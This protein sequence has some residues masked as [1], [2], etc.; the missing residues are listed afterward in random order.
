[1]VSEQVGSALPILTGGKATANGSRVQPAGTRRL[2][3]ESYTLPIHARGSG[4]LCRRRVVSKRCLNSDVSV[5]RVGLSLCQRRGRRYFAQ[6]SSPPA[7]VRWVPLSP[8]ALCVR[9]WLLLSS[10]PIPRL[11]GPSRGGLPEP[12]QVE[13][14]NELGQRLFP[15][16]VPMIVDLPELL[17]VHAEFARHLHVGMGK[18]MAAA[19]VDLYLKFGRQL[20]RLALCH[21][22]AQ[23]R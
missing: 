4:R 9:S 1:M 10:A 11:T 20:P 21:R 16:L 22:L 7:G 17:R 5:Y 3:R 12:L 23:W 13:L 8:C 14:F 19:C 6:T 2:W 18:T 15:W